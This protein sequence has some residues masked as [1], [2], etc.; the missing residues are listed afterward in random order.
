M[1][2]QANVLVSRRPQI[3]LLLE[4]YSL[5]ISVIR[6]FRVLQKFRM[7]HENIYGTVRSILIL[8]FMVVSLYR[9]FETTLVQ[10]HFFRS[11][12]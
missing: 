4:M 5:V 8:I 7:I 9:G 10:K 12:L 2:S 3:I 1:V 6:L 11:L